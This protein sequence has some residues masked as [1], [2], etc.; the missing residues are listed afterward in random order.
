M[1]TIQLEDQEIQYIL[2]VISERPYKESAQLIVK[3][4]QQVQ[5]PSPEPED[6]AEA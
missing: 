5:Q 3:I 2:N 1:K 6:R 4:V